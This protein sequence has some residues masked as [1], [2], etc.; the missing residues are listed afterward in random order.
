ML[1]WSP[2]FIKILMGFAFKNEAQ[3]LNKSLTFY[4]KDICLAFRLFQ[5]KIASGC[6]FDVNLAPFFSKETSQIASWKHLGRVLGYFGLVL[7]RLRQSWK[8]LGL[9]WAVLEASW[10]RLGRLLARL[11]PS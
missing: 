10:R 2:L 1:S 7:G 4:L 11:G 5:H 9:S 3:E 6:D 8:R